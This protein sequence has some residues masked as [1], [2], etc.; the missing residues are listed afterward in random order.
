MSNALDMMITI[1][2]INRIDSLVNKLNTRR[3]T[4]KT[5]HPQMLIQLGDMLIDAHTHRIQLH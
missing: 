1:N 2:I 5:H 3:N 4:T